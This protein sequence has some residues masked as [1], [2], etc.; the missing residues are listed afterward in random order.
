[1][2][3][4]KINGLSILLNNEDSFTITLE[5]GIELTVYE[6]LEDPHRLDVAVYSEDKSYEI[7]TSGRSQNSL[8]LY[9]MED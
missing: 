9:P 7:Y 4:V 1:M 8:T 6:N 3:T 5:N 2:I